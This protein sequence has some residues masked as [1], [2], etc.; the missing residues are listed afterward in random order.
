MKRQL[1]A[2]AA[3][4]VLAI[5]AA[6]PVSAKEAPNLALSAKASAPGNSEW[7][8][9]PFKMNDGN[10]EEAYVS[11]K[12]TLP[13]DITLTWAK[14]QTFNTLEFRVWYA[15]GQGIRAFNIWV[16]ADGK[17]NWQKVAGETD[18]EYQTSSHAI[19]KKIFKFPKQRAKALKLE[20]TGINEDWNQFAIN[21]LL[22]R[23]E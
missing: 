13:E 18:L 12:P 14:A 8:S 11:Q 9:T 2:P 1:T 15:K 20:V 23:Q 10:E 19:E 16:S 17:G 4:L 21:E 7:G 6:Y 22:I 5:A 3:L